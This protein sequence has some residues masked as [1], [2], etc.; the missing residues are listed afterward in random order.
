MVTFCPKEI[1]KMALGYATKNR[2]KKLKELQDESRAAF[3]KFAAVIPHGMDFSADAIILA[4]D[5]AAARAKAHAEYI[6]I[7]Y[8]I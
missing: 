3:K 1:L 6:K 5:Y 7:L 4:V 8:G 2:Q